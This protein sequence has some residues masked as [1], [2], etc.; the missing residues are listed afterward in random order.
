MADGAA[1]PRGL[2]V[3]EFV[4]RVLLASTPPGETGLRAERGAGRR[5][6]AE[7]ARAV[8]EHRSRVDAASSG[9]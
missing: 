8:P 4:K 2:S 1:T 3:Q 7:S 5:P 9:A 6:G